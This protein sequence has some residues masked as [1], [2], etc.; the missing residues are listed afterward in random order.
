MVKYISLGMDCCIAYQLNLHENN[1][2]S[3]ILPFDWCLSKNILDIINIFETNWIHF[4]NKDN[5]VIESI[6]NNNFNLGL[7]TNKSKFRVKHKI[8]KLVYPHDLLEPN[9]DYF[10]DKYTRRINRLNNLI[11]YSQTNLITDRLHNLITSSQTNLIAEEIIFIRIGT[12]K[13][14]IHID[15]LNNLLKSIF[16]NSK[17]KFIN[18]MD[19]KTTDWKRDNI[20]WKKIINEL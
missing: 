9:I 20:D 19:Y 2:Y 3:G 13:D 7:S 8:Y 10:I 4:L 14:I 16:I 1:N 11:T 5:W 17:L 6:D 18:S 15:K 12:N